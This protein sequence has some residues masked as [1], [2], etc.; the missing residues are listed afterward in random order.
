MIPRGRVSLSFAIMAMV[1]LYC[2]PQLAAQTSTESPT[3]STAATP[4]SHTKNKDDQGGGKVG[5]DFR[6]SSLGLGGEVAYEV[7]HSSN[8]RGGVNYFT[9][10]RGFDHNGINFNG[11]LRWLSGEA[12]YDWFPFA[13]FAHSFHLSPGLIAYNDNRVNATASIAAGNT[14]SLNHVSYESNPANP[15]GGTGT[16]AFNKVAPTFM[17]GFGNMVPRRHGK[18]FSVNI[19]AGV[20]FQGS[21]KVGLN[22]TG[23]ACAVGTSTCSNVATDPTVQSNVHGEQTIISNDLNPFKY[24]PLLALSFGYRF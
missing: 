7:T 9:Y 13:H 4:K 18:H 15:V 21:P 3:V 16:L 10:S 6:V 17:I 12:H 23:S 19:E 11:D 22:L 5:V 1:F 8:V 14:F 20:A 24:Y 2:A